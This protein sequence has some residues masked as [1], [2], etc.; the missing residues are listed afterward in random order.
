MLENFKT[1]DSLAF[2]KFFQRKLLQ[3]YIEVRE[4]VQDKKKKRHLR[5][6]AI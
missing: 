5:N 3:E 6:I 4:K 1:I 2:F